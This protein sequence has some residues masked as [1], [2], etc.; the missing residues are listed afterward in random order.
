MNLFLK[1]TLLSQILAAVSHNEWPGQPLIWIALEN[2]IPTSI[3]CRLLQSHVGGIAGTSFEV[4]IP[5]PLQA[6]SSN[7]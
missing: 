2:K 4:G 7:R 6:K 3:V 5:F 1:W